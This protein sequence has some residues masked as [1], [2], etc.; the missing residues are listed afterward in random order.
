MTE[1]A[2]TQTVH[3]TQTMHATENLLMHSDVA[4]QYRAPP[5]VLIKAPKW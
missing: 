1:K 3:K 2:G 5:K 4:A